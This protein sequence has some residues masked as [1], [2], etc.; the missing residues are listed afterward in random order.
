[1]PSACNIWLFHG[2]SISRWHFIKLC[3]RHRNT[4]SHSDLS[5]LLWLDFSIDFQNGSFQTL[6][7]IT[8][9]DRLIC[10]DI[11]LRVTTLVFISTEA[12]IYDHTLSQGGEKK[13]CQHC[14]PALVSVHESHEL[15][16]SASGANFFPKIATCSIFYFEC[17]FHCT[18]LSSSL[19]PHRPGACIMEA[20]DR[21]VTTVFT[22]Q[23]SFHHRHSTNRVSW[24]VTL[25][26]ERAVTPHLVVR[27]RW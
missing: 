6:E 2:N 27:R 22:V 3:Y 14:V 5:L 23:T 12:C 15:G 24:S 26:G 8:T 25:V 10:P 18:L 13:S 21:Q 19:S 20:D 16:F 9:P 1:M 4:S 11:P 7:L 17:C